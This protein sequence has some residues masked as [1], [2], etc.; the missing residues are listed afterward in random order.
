M[1]AKAGHTPRKRRP[2]DLKAARVNRAPVKRPTKCLCPRCGRTYIRYMD[3]TGR[4]TPRKY[5]DSCLTTEEVQ[6]GAL[7][8][9]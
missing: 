4:G 9:L 1:N 6:Y 5:C 3:W 2:S 7:I 8:H